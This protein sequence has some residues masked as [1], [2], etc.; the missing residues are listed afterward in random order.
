MKDGDPL[1]AGGGLPA[2]S[3]T[4]LRGPAVRRL[5]ALRTGEKLTAGHVRVAADALGVS[6]R[7]VW[8]W[9]AA[10]AA[11]ETAAVHPGARS[12]ADTRFTI[13]PEVRGL[14]AL[15][16]GNVRAVHREL[17]LRAARQ[18]P[19]ADVPSLTTLHRALRRDL[20]PGERAGLAAGERAARKHDVFLSR[21]RGWRNQVWETDHV[22][23]PVL[24]D[25]DGKARRPWITW[26]TDCATNA[27]TGV[28]VTPGHPSRE[29][30]LAALRSAVLREEPY[31]PLGG[32]PEKVRVDRGKDFLSRTVTAA[33]DVL[34]VTV[35]DLPAYT[36]HLK[37]TVEGLNRAVESMFLAALPGYARQ[38]RPGKRPSRP[39]DEVLLS[40]ED[41]S[42][43]A[44][45]DTV[46]EHRAPPR[47]AAW[48]DPAGGVAD[49][50]D[51]AAGRAGRG[52]VDVHPGGRRYPRAD[53]PRCP[54]QETRL[55]GAVDDRPGGDPGE[56]PFHAPP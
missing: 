7:T 6:E 36:P 52:S 54:L 47:P 46:V 56:G 29:S 55:R 43:A 21:R 10:A 49:R 9:L 1:R 2:A 44:G 22:Q 18:S 30:V 33:F 13:T 12:R 48:P 23:A 20:A 26:F 8:R 14:L 41:F 4:A 25:V 38:P 28:A 27:I 11:D 3:R 39:R 40:F 5:L 19:P 50:P 51:P 42:P 53:H 15:W 37:G 24:V 17:V 34:D 16:K 31:G 45:L 32:L 35:E